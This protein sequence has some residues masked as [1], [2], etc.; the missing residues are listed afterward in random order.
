MTDLYETLG[1]DK[2]AEPGEIRKAYKKK[3]QQNHP[4]REGGDVDEFK[5]IAHAY[6]V[7]I[8][9]DRRSR[10]DETGCDDNASAKAAEDVLM[11]CFSSAIDEDVEGD[12]VE[13]IKHHMNRRLR[14]FTSNKEKFER[15]LAKLEKN[16]GRV[17]SKGKNLYELVI[18][19]KIAGINSSIQTESDKIALVTEALTLLEAY[20]DN[21]PKMPDDSYQVFGDRGFFHFGNMGP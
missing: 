18:S 7:L 2:N 5:Q 17:A 3:A 16:Q 12:I 9:P 21:A 1:V 19:Q 10:Y 13:A 15:K 8:D 6:S 4:D 11:S 14:E 20:T